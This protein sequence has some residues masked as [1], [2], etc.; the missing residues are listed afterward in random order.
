[1][2]RAVFHSVPFRRSGVRAEPPRETGRAGDEGGPELGRRHVHGLLA[3]GRRLQ[4]RRHARRGHRHAEGQ[5]QGRA[6]RRK[7]ETLAGPSPSPR[8]TPSHLSGR[9][10]H[11]EPDQLPEHLRGAARRLLRVLDRGGRRGRRPPRRPDHR[12]APLH[13]PEQR[14]Q[15][16][17]RP[18]LRQV[19][20][21]R[22]ASRPVRAGP[23]QG[24]RRVE[25]PFRARRGLRR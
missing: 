5:R 2:P 15:L 4:G 6:P 21:E 14:G 16:R 22:A 19:P 18:D 17:G 20:E 12:R 11:L 1:M 7:G 13:R 24:R 9:P 25:G 8:L 23:H 3:G 10:V